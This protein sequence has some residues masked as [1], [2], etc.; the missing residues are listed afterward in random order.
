MRD[1]NPASIP[2]GQYDLGGLVLDEILGL[3]QSP[4]HQRIRM[5]RLL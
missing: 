4:L 2:E 1:V 3:N 5:H